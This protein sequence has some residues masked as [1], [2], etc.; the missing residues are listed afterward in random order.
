MNNSIT[1]QQYT[2]LDTAYTFYK[3][4]LFENN[5][6]DCMIILNRKG[7]NNLGYFHPDRF[8]ERSDSKKKSKASELSLNPD[9]FLGRS[10]IQILSTL[11]H[12]MVHVWQYV[13]E[14]LPKNGYH[15]KSF[16]KKMEEIGLMASNT[17]KPGGKKTG[18][19]MD[20]YIIEKGKFETASKKFLSSKS[21]KWMSYPIPPAQ[22]VK[23]NKTK[24]T[25]PSCECNAWGKPELKLICG[26][27]DEEMS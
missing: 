5:L 27:C 9:N 10:D 16:G 25:C 3:K 8:I 14:C 15:D 1:K 21:I 24:F 6:P 11:V 4:A 12:E 13:N 19:Q 26:D 17:G 20:H 23:K 18:Q 7:K 22:S 2:T